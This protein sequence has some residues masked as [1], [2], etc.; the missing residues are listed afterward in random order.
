VDELPFLR[1]RVRHLRTHLTGLIPPE[2][3]SPLRDSAGFEPDFLA[4]VVDGRSIDPRY[5]AP[6]MAATAGLTPVS[7]LV[8]HLRWRVGPPEGDDLR[9]AD[10]DADRLVEVVAA[11]GPGR[12]SG[13]PQVLASLFWQ[14]YAYR[15]GGTTLAAWVA[16]GSAPDPTAPGT[17]VGVARSRPASLV[18]DPDARPLERL[19]DV[20]AGVL[21]NLDAVSTALRVHHRLGEQLVH[22]NALAG[23]ASALGAVVTAESAPPLAERAEAALR[24]LPWSDL[25]EWSTAPWAFRRRTCCL[26]WK[27]TAADGALCEDCSLR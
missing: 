18:V 1:E 21:A 3:A 16:G 24:A 11:T 15:L 9:S 26:W 6:R 13:D 2:G 7:D 10:L 27:T 14:A 23:I 4:F 12:G 5:R 20:V 19:E 8:A 17:G 22:G 25:A